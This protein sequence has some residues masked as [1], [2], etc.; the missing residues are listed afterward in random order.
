MIRKSGAPFMDR[1][2]ARMS[3]HEESMLAEE[4][5][6]LEASNIEDRW[7]EANFMWTSTFGSR[8]ILTPLYCR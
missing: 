8:I 2:E 1:Q 3:P 5:I 6:V 7:L 4:P